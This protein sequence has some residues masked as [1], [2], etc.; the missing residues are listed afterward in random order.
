MY[1]Y[2]YFGHTYLGHGNLVR[3]E[4]EAVHVDVIPGRQLALEVNPGRSLFR[5]RNDNAGGGGGAQ[6]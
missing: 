4:I 5:S 6:G 2:T 3:A 1:A